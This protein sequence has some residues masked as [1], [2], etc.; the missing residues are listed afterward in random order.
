MN[1]LG[2][3]IED[4]PAG[5]Y[6]AD[7]D[8]IIVYCNQWAANIFGYESAQEF[9]GINLNS[10]YVNS[11]E[12][13]DLLEDVSRKG[14][15]N[16][17]RVAMKKKNGE[18]VVISVN[19]RYVTNGN[20]ESGVRGVFT[21]V[22]DMDSYESM[23]ENLHIGLYQLD[24][25]MRIIRCN[26]GFE[27]IFGYGYREMIGLHAS[28]LYDDKYDFDK[29]GLDLQGNKDGIT[30][31]YLEM[32][33]KDGQ[34][35][36]ISLSTHFRSDRFGNNMGR[37]GTVTEVSLSDAIDEGLIKGSCHVAIPFGGKFDLI[38]KECIKDL[39]HD[40]EYVFR[41]ADDQ[42]STEG[43]LR[44]KILGRIEDSSFVLVDVTN[45]NPNV[46]YEVGIAHALGKK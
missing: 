22:T 21:D 8:G 7:K 32:R 5:I 4:I 30:S 11:K 39:N 18:R 42:V 43:W 17:F 44:D 13:V 34:R 2:S 29:L 28:L 24:T 10:M 31:R 15:S 14:V 1:S 35:V 41:R 46:I 12:R 36:S 37:E 3:F 6:Q 25:N 26:R 40:S 45:E 20:R 16:G 33:K 27:K 23:F 19:T 38:F 9:I